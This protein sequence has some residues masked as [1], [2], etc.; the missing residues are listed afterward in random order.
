MPQWSASYSDG[1][2]T[3]EALGIHLT[4]VEAAKAHDNFVRNSIALS[5]IEIIKQL[6]FRTLGDYLT[7]AQAQAQ[8]NINNAEGFI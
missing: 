2:G 7:P 4:E 3:I 8:K 1:K 5:S 6:N